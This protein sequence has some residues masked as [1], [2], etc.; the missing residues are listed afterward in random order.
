MQ[1]SLGSYYICS[2]EFFIA[3]FSCEVSRNMQ[4]TIWFYY[5]RVP[6]ILTLD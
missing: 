2:F 4:I 5:L 6:A 3:C 1:C